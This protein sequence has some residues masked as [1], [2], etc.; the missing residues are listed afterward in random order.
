MVY[1]HFGTGVEYTPG[2]GDFS[3][4]DWNSAPLWPG[5]L[6]RSPNGFPSALPILS[7]SPTRSHQNDFSLTGIETIRN[8]K[9]R[10]SLG[11]GFASLVAI[12]VSLLWQS[13]APHCPTG[14]EERFASAPVRL[15]RGGLAPLSGER[16][17]T[18][19]RC[20]TE[21]AMSAAA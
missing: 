19:G 16:A 8:D 4:Q 13:A 17:A 7:Q 20:A 14:L 3:R 6:F 15:R 12:G 18:R 11:R 9:R 10:C 21:V 1:F 5:P 2:A